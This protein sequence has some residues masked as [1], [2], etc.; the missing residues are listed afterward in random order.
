MGTTVPIYFFT[1]SG[2][3]FSASEIGQKITPTFDN[4]SRKVVPIETLSKIASTA[5]FA[6]RFCSVNGIP[7]FS[8][9][10]KI[11][12]SISSKFLAF[13]CDLGAE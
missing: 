6:K 8:K 1:K 2:Y 12:P 4:S 11:S 5:T 9:V 3:D 7:N 10:F 13:P